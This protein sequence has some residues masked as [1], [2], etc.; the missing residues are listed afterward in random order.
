MTFRMNIDHRLEMRL[1]RL[2]TPEILEQYVKLRIKEEE[3]YTEGFNDPPVS[4]LLLWKSHESYPEFFREHLYAS[5]IEYI[6]GSYKE[7][8]PD[9]ESTNIVSDLAEQL[10]ENG[11][12]C[13]TKHKYID[14]LDTGL[15]NPGCFEQGKRR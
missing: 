10:L 13:L 12:I 9:S 2:V 11:T 3:M 6:R 15:V 14:V 4:R 7:D 8:H 5:I 1:K